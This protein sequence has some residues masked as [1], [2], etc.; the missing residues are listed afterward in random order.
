MPASDYSLD[1]PVPAELLEIWGY[2]ARDNIEAA[3]RVIDAS[4]ATFRLIAQSPG[5][6][7]RCGFRIARLQDV[8]FRAVEGFDNY[9]IF[10]R[11]T[12]R[13]VHI[14]HVLHK[15]RKVERILRRR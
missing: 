12:E 5:I 10:Y 1:L 11:K 9:L 15:A 4:H 8:Y 7:K 14:I 3:D 6:G 2:I 13:G